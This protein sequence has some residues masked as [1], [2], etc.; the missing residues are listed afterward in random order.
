MNR[1]RV[2]AVRWLPLFIWMSLIFVVSH[3]SKTAIP[4]YGQWDLL[5]K[6]SGHFL[7]YS[8]LALLAYRAGLSVTASLLLSVAYAASDELHQRLVPGRNGT[9][10]DV[11]IDALGA[12]MALYL[13]RLSHRSWHVFQWDRINTPDEQ[14]PHDAL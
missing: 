6:K 12:T 8:I 1:F 9:A 4:S 10:V 2:L 14:S 5:V 7:A 3:Q 13:L 11:L